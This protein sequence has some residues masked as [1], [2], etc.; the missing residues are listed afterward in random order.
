MSRVLIEISVVE[1]AVAEVLSFPNPTE[2][3]PLRRAICFFER[4]DETIVVWRVG[5]WESNAWENGERG[6]GASGGEAVG[7]ATRSSRRRN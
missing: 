2:A 3:V 1:E 7:E 4:G 5:N 6:S